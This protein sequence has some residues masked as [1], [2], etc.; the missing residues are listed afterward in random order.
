M[1]EIN[2]VG[3]LWDS[4]RNLLQPSAFSDMNMQSALCL[5]CNHG[6]CP[7]A[8]AQ[9]QPW[10]NPLLGMV[11]VLLHRVIPT[12]LDRKGCPDRRLRLVTDHSS[13]PALH[14]FLESVSKTEFNH[15]DRR[16]HAEQ[17][18]S[19]SGVVLHEHG[20]RC[21]ENEGSCEK[22]QRSR[23]TSPGFDLAQGARRNAVDNISFG[24]NDRDSV[25][26]TVSRVTS[27]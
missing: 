1:I 16:E 9:Q 14:G 27:A 2:Q 15:R 11:G 8:G 12:P 5:R 3:G 18:T 26:G 7:P 25:R 17:S 20:V 24:A 10:G 13:S 22:I 6:N 4:D 23:L 19:H 21:G